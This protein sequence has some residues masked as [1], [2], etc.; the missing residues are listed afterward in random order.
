M[1]PDDQLDDRKQTECSEDGPKHFWRLFSDGHA[2]GDTAGGR[3]V[4]VR[5]GHHQEQKSHWKG[6]NQSVEL[7]VVYGEGLDG[8]GEQYERKH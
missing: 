7:T 6:H 4:G 8:P 5:N 2:D 1:P 3:M